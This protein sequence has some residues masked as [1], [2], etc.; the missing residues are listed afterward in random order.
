MTDKEYDRL[1]HVGCEQLRTP[2]LNTINICYGIF[3][4]TDMGIPNQ[5]VKEGFK[6]FINEILENGVYPL[7]YDSKTEKFYQMKFIYIN[8]DEIHLHDNCNVFSEPNYDIKARLG[9]DIIGTAS[10]DRELMDWYKSARNNFNKKYEKIPSNVKFIHPDMSNAEDASSVEASKIITSDD[11]VSL[12]NITEFSVILSKVISLNL[13]YTAKFN[14]VDFD[15]NV[16]YLTKEDIIHGTL[17]TCS[18]MDRLVSSFNKIKNGTG[19][20]IHYRSS[21]SFNTRS[22]SET[23]KKKYDKDSSL[24]LVASDN[25]VIPDIY[26]EEIGVLNY[27]I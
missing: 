15:K 23:E 20:S 27:Q 9:L 16:S 18:S 8:I 21:V 19:R 1:W 24:N 26:C 4:N 6:V 11:Y 12:V 5:N 14:D 22:L 2:I 7:M 3:E 13:T 25:G 10:I 17:L